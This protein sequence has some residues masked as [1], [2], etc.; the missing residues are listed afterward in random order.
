MRILVTGAAG[1]FGRDLVPLLAKDHQ[2]RATDVRP[3]TVPCEFAQADLLDDAA[4]RE[5]VDG[6]DAIIHLAAHLPTADW[7][8]REYLEVNAAATALLMKDAAAA[9]VDHFIYASTIWATGHGGET[10]RRPLTEDVPVAPICEYGVTKYM[11][12]VA[13]EFFARTTPMRVTVLRATGYERCGEIGPDG[14]IDW[15]RVDWTQLVFYL[16]R[17]GQKLFDPLDLLDAF[18]AAL[19]LEDKFGRFIV[20]QQWPFRAEDAALLDEEP[21][22]AWEKY[23]PQAAR[24]FSALGVN[25]PPIDVWYSVDRFTEAT[26]WRQRITLGQVA[27]RF[28]TMHGHRL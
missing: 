3:V 9:G 18:E 16:T 25:P 17:A 23:Y 8:L 15:A 28:F 24:L 13:A 4:R 1:D 10:D 12:E 26:G 21:E 20:G 5:L 6:V 27:R 14:F 7:T 19:K 22:L 2:V 11:G